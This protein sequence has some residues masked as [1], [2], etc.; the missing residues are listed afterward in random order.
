MTDEEQLREK[1]RK[2]S[3]LFEGA[4]T[5]GERNAAAAAIERVRRA[6]GATMRTEQP[7]EFQFTLPDRWQRR[8]FAA[9]CRRYGLEPYRYKR[10]RYTTLVVRAPRTFVD[11]TLWPEY[12]QLK[13][14][15]DQYLNDAT[16]RIIRE[17]VYRDAGEAPA[18]T[19]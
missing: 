7:Q 6:L 1:L 14:A 8:L 15:L 19:G 2:I 12:Q 13:G 18:R 11:R 16:E 5:I 9:L 17:E 4:T 3:A 10:Q